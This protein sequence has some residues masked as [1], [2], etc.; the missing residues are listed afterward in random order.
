[1]VSA[2]RFRQAFLDQWNDEIRNNREA[3]LKHRP[4]TSSWKTPWT[5]YM[6]SLL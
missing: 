5:A 3:L 2:R 6:L 4:G 1:M